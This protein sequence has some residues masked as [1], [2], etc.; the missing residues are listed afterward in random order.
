MQK[1]TLFVV[2]LALALCLGVASSKLLAADVV[3]T[4]I[5]RINNEVI[6]SS[7]LNRER[8]LLH[9]ELQGHF[10]GLQLQ[11]EFQTRE[12]DL[13]RQLIDNSLL[14]QKGKEEG[15]SAEAETIKQMDGYRKQAKLKDM[16]ELEKY[17]TE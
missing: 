10:T 2:F 11:T 12:K 1:S 15:I 6:T 13:L 8:E 3:E 16:E 17:V 9:Q 14:L 4:T 7:E 5:P